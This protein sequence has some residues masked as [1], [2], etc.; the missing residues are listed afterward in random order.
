MVREVS[1]SGSSSWSGKGQGKEGKVR[2]HFFLRHGR[3]MWV[4]CGL[5]EDDW[6]IWFTLHMLLSEP[7]DVSV[8]CVESVQYLCFKQLKT[9]LQLSLGRSHDFSFP[10][11]SFLCH[12]RSTIGV[13]S[14]WS[15]RKLVLPVLCEFMSQNWTSYEFKV[16]KIW[17]LH[18]LNNAIF[19]SWSWGR[20]YQCEKKS[21]EKYNFSKTNDG[22]CPLLV[23]LN[24]NG[25][26]EW[27]TK[28]LCC[29]Y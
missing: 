24:Y 22:I 4:V 19:Q 5:G 23:I 6:Q 15:I 28:I 7:V 3:K 18:L 29:G 11:F 16:K 14:H 25:G 9:A 17:V 8:T 27:D 10:Y 26:W 13:P 1:W 12:C 21:E 2:G 20:K